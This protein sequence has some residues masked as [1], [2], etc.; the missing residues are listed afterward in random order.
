MNT[1]EIHFAAFYQCYFSTYSNRI[2]LSKWHQ[3]SSRIPGIMQLEFRSQQQPALHNVAS[4]IL[5]M[6]P[7]Y[8][9]QLLQRDPIPG[10]ASLSHPFFKREQESKNVLMKNVYLIF[11]KFKRNIFIMTLMELKGSR[12]LQFQNICSALP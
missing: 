1:K 12:Q 4:I 6:K 2:L 11:S 9:Q 10:M 7:L 5:W 8:Y 3:D